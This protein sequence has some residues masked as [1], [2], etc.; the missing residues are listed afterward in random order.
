MDV[1]F[2]RVAGLDVGK[3]S[4]TVCVR[5]PGADRKRQSRTRTFSTMTRSLG[6]MADW[7]VGEGVTLAAMES[8]ATYWKPVLYCLEERME[9]W[10]LNA[11]HMKAVPGR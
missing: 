6:V 7:L 8:T 9:C 5:T 11:A 2:D 1:L 4:V 10:L 3:A